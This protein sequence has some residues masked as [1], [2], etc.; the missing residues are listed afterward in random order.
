MAEHQIVDLAVAGSN[1]ASHPSFTPGQPIS[2]LL[3]GRRALERLCIFH[4]EEASGDASERRVGREPHDDPGTAPG[5][6]DLQSS[7]ALAR[8]PAK[9]SSRP[10][11]VTLN[12]GQQQ[13]TATV[14]SEIFGAIGRE[15]LASMAKILDAL[16][17]AMSATAPEDQE[18][19]DRTSARQGD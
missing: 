17:A 5:I 6:A 13:L 8:T 9:G 3:F 19:R 2:F 11:P 7:E 12:P 16:E 18:R 1:P 10:R 14:L 15:Q 4:S